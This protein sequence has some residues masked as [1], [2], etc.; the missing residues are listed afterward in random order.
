MDKNN[1]KNCLLAGKVPG[2]VE[3]AYM[4]VALAI[5]DDLHLKTGLNF[6]ISVA[7]CAYYEERIKPLLDDL[8]RNGFS[9]EDYY[10]V[11]HSIS[12]RYIVNETINRDF[13]SLT[14][15]PKDVLSDIFLIMH[16]GPKK[17]NNVEKLSSI[18]FSGEKQ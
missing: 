9:I 6:L 5:K 1:K 18:K 14:S 11:R 13:N 2:Y 7:L 8:A 10:K 3:D 16:S 17:E 12:Y 15:L 4:K